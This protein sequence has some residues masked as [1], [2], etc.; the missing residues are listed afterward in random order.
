MIPNDGAVGRALIFGAT[1]FTGR[2]VVRQLAEGGAEV[3]AHVRPESRSA[4]RW[5]ASFRSWGAKVARTPWERGALQGLVRDVAPDAVFLL[6]GT[7]KRRAR[8][9][10]L[11]GDIYDQ[12]DRGLSVLAIEAAVRAHAEANRSQP[13]A[14]PAGGGPG[15]RL[16]YLSAVGADAGTKNAYLAARVEVEAAL[17]GSGLPFVIARPSFIHGPGRERPRLGEAVGAAVADAALRVAGWVGA[18]RLRDRYRSIDD[19]T[20]ARALIHLAGSPDAVGRV[21]L[22]EDLQRLGG[23]TPER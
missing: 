21:F 18:R 10:G 9:E 2:E 19:A 23:A 8:E 20:L 15:P 12:V 1:G 14:A 16:I 22:G 11:R 4:P 3:I 6:L 7:T 5:E 13:D 17:R